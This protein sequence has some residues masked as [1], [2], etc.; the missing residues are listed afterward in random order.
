[1][2]QLSKI[3][4][5][6][7]DDKVWTCSIGGNVDLPRGSDLP[8]RVAVED[9]FVRVTGQ[10]PRACF[11]GWGGRWDGVQV[12]CI[13][14]RESTMDEF[15]E[16]DIEALRTRCLAAEADRDRYLARAEAAEALVEKAYREG[17]ASGCAYECGYSDAWDS[18]DS[19][20]TSNARAALTKEASDAA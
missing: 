9:A 20:I 11:S 10:P 18:A 17:F 7:K 16:L 1:M 12:A 6:C 2:R 4:G 15:A 13:E 8:M 19:W 5:E 3:L 14:K